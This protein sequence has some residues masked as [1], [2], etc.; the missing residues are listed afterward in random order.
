MK[1]IKLTTES[2]H[3]FYV[4]TDDLKAF[5]WEVEHGTYIERGGPDRDALVRESVEH[6]KLELDKL[7]K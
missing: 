5:G 7:C 3:I 1:F 6:I 4:N 2:G